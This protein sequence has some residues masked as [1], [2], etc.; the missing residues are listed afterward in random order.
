MH[1]NSESVWPLQR[2][3]GGG[4]KKH[5]PS[6]VAVAVLSYAASM[7]LR[8][9]VPSWI[10][11]LRCGVPSW[12]NRPT[13]HQDGVLAAAAASPAPEDKVSALK[14]AKQRLR[15]ELQESARALKSEQKKTRKRKAAAAKLTEEEHYIII[16]IIRIIILLVRT[17]TTCV[18][19]R[20]PICRGLP[21]TTRKE[22]VEV[23]ISR[24]N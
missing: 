16:I 10:N 21:R 23:L 18:C 19:A 20:P 22:L 17:H 12:I 5:K 2:A 11:R 14:A 8:C 24:Q 15:A 7:W 6:R 3:N 9:G 1:N 13:F 4:K